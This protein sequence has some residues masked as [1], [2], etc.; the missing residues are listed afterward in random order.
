MRK[1]VCLIVFLSLVGEVKGGIYG[2]KWVTPW[3]IVGDILL[4][5]QIK[6]P[7]LD[8]IAVGITAL[9]WKRLGPTYCAPPLLRYIKLSLVATL[10]LWV[11]G[12][13]TG[14]S[15]YQTI[16]QLHGFVMLFAFATMILTT[17]QT[18][19]DFFAL[20]MTL[21]A[22]ALVR[23]SMAFLFFFTVLPTLSIQ[24]GDVGSGF[25]VTTHSDTAL[26]VTGI[27]I[28]VAWALERPSRKSVA[29]AVLVTV[30]LAAAIQVNNRRLAWVSLIA[31]FF[32]LYALLPENKVKRAVR[33]GAI[34]LAPV[35]VAYVAVGWG[36]TEGIFKPVGSLSTMFGKKEDASSETRNIENYNLIQTLKTN[37]LLGTGWGHEYREISVA[38]SIAEIFPQYRYIPHNSV[39]GLLAFTGILG[40]AGTWMVL[41]VTVYLAARVVRASK[42]S[43]ERVAALV[44]VAEVAIYGNQAYGDMGLGTTTCTMLLACGMAVAGR[45]T[46]LSGAWPAPRSKR[47]GSLGNP[48]GDPQTP[49]SEE[50]PVKV[51]ERERPPEDE[52][53]HEPHRLLETPSGVPV[54]GREHRAHDGQDDDRDHDEFGHG[55]PRA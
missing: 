13:V 8:I 1:F 3:Q 6:F 4:V 22:A 40:F 31:G 51:G 46:I 42:D 38:Y 43:I 30:Y 44:T 9:C 32:I 52:D 10:V 23:A 21:V 55:A 37:P 7:L 49:P 33:R 54:A 45:V 50:A 2:G 25:C 26:F 34:Y 16:F 15:A 19:K 12:L 36:R 14:G 29:A 47:A 17:M 5:P 53:R 24:A 20:G 18:R 11:W 39:L 48:A 35:L 41:P 28:P 27:L